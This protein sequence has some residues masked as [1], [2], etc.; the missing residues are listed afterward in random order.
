MKNL[1]RYSFIFYYTLLYS[2][3]FGQSPT[4][5]TARNAIRQSIFTQPTTIVT[6]GLSTSK[7]I[8]TIKYFDGLGRPLQE[9]GYQQSPNNKDIILNNVSYDVISRPS[10]T[11]LPTPT[12][13]ATGGHVSDVN[14]LAK[15]FYDNDNAPFSK[16]VYEASPLNRV[17]QQYGAGQAWQNTNRAINTS[18]EVAAE[19]IR[20]YEVNSAK[21]IVLSGNFV[22]GT[23]F[24]LRTTDE[25]G[26]QVVE[27]KDAAGHLILK[28]IQDNTESW[29]STYYIYDN[30]WRLVAVIQP[31]A[32]DLNQT[33]T[34]NS[35]NWNEGIFY[36]VYDNESRLVS[37]KVP[38]AD[39]EY[40][41]FD[42]W[43][44]MVWS[45]DG[46]QRQ[47]NLWKFYKYDNYNRLILSGIKTDTRNQA[48][49]QAEANAWTGS[50]FESISTQAPYY[51]IT[52]SYPSNITIAD[53][54]TLT[55][56]DDYQYWLPT[57]MFFIANDYASQPYTS[58]KGLQTGSATKNL[59]NNT[60]LYKAMY[61][62]KKA[63][64]IQHLQHNVYNKIDRQ[65]FLYAFD[66]KVLTQRN[67]WTLANGTS[68]I[69][70]TQ[71]AYDLTNRPT[72]V[73]HGFSATTNT[74]I[75]Q[76]KYDE[77]GRLIQ[78]KI[79]PNSNIVSNKFLKGKVLLAGGIGVSQM[80]T[81]MASS[82]YLPTLE[83][84]TALGGRFVH[85]GGGGNEQTTLQVLAANQ[86]T[87]NAIV[88]WVFVE[89][90]SASNSANILKT[91]SALLQA[92]GD[93]VDIDGVSD[94]N[95]GNLPNA[96]YYVA[97]KHRNHLGVM[98]AEAVS[99]ASTTTT[100]NFI[101]RTP[102]Q[103]YNVVSDYD[104]GE[105]KNTSLGY[106]LWAGDANRDGMVIYQ[107]G[108]NDIS[109]VFAKVFS[110]PGNVTH[111]NNYIVYGYNPEDITL[112]GMVIYQGPNNENNYIFN[113]IMTHPL[114]VEKL[115]IFLVEEQIPPNSVVVP[116]SVQ[117]S[118]LQ[119]IDYRYHI[120]GGLLGI[121]LN[122][123]GVPVPNASE[124]DLFS[125]RLDYETSNQWDGN[126]GK[127]T[128]TN[129]QNQQ[130]SYTFSYDISKRLKSAVYTGIGP[131]NYG[132]PLITYDKNG[133][134]T[135]LQRNG[136]VGS[137][138]GLMDN[139]T[140][141]YTGNKLY[142]VEDAI[143]GDNIVDFVNR[144]AVTNDYDYYS[145]GSLKKDLN[146]EISQ[147]DY[148]PYLKLPKQISLTNNR[149]IK[150][151]YAGDGR[152]LKRTYSTGEYWEYDGSM[153]YKNGQP[154]QL[155]TPEGRATYVSNAW[156]YEYNIKDHLGNVRVSFKS[157]SGVLQ[158]VESTNYDPFGIELNGT[159]T[160]N[161][162]ENR[163]KYQDKES[164][165]LFGLSG[166]N[167]FGAR[168][169][170]KTIG[171][172]WGVDA[173]AD[174][175][176]RHSPYQYNNNNPLRFIDPDGMSSVGAD[177]L[178]TDQWVAARGDADAENEA[179]QE[180]RNKDR[181]KREDAQQTRLSYKIGSFSGSDGDLGRTP[182]AGISGD[183]DS[184][185]DA[186]ASFTRNFSIGIAFS[187]TGNGNILL[188]HF[189]N[190]D[191][192]PINFA[193]TSDMA[194]LISNNGSFKSF[195]RMFGEVALN[196]F[197]KN[198]TLSDFDGNLALESLR[199]QYF[200]GIIRD[201]LFSWTVMG[202]YQ[203]M[204]V[205]ITNISSSKVGM[206]IKIGDIFG[207][208][209]GDANSNLPGLSEMYNLQHNYG[210]G[211]KYNPFPWAVQIKTEHIKTRNIQ[212]KF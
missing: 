69:E 140:Y 44:R 158:Q 147:I 99:F 157:N 170:D 79:A 39:W 210:R 50:R 1:L 128:W 145:D 136:K 184:E 47:S 110:D 191:G 22:A 78:K 124:S 97:I 15:S 55:Y 85:V 10:T 130:R 92:D 81:S 114:N 121:N 142:K 3:T 21:D 118:A 190:G 192:S 23:L 59:E 168:Y 175:S 204:Q 194:N 2:Q 125:Y 100:V 42:K 27:F 122:S 82:G 161:S 63:R 205:D 152:V 181:K 164:L 105:R 149:W 174:I 61:Y 144:N 119:T 75:A 95:L 151:T 115:N 51:T 83:P 182:I 196:Y 91:R 102:A 160:A 186:L 211:N 43:D 77:V 120:R 90:R 208:G 112:D 141:T 16:T 14:T 57:G 96:N 4:I 49:L 84:Y 40:F 71:N 171:R 101:T 132:I 148:D 45:Q 176:R 25:Q 169:Y 38:S 201:N 109:Y 183:T 189:L 5:T 212:T 126:I 197:S 202:G 177:G 154:Y 30:L 163:F 28:Q 93:I 46:L 127:Q 29:L 6:D 134:I 159:G 104:G 18:Y 103:I 24:K 203:Y 60:W 131:E 68:T 73:R 94:L 199:P 195:V 72:S 207:A 185:E 56:F 76:L 11:H 156:A 32:Y 200:G 150:I 87:P 111:L 167:D 137:G 37:K 64:V 80:N 89:L 117:L 58:A 143:S 166:I 35:S 53:I 31:N 54:Y 106:A 133:N 138:Y 86:G 193:S 123:T 113:S 135:T 33:L 74:E 20:R 12:T 66:G 173:L 48:T 153:V 108:G 179:R 188:N 146:K 41:V 139:L 155:S 198:S 7:A 206:T 9:V 19:N 172:W 116:S 62:D 17:S 8:I 162:V 165:T 26:H 129:A 180:N 107:G 98:T 13:N 70:N 65:D 67:Y 36:Y 178:T 88:D 187:L 52:S 209:R 34:A